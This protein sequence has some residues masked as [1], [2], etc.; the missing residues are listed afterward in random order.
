MMCE[1]TITGP[2][3]DGYV[4][5]HWTDEKGVRYMVN[6]SLDEDEYEADTGPGWMPVATEG[7]FR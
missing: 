1:P 5:A 7:A 6:L 4:W 2:D 3:A